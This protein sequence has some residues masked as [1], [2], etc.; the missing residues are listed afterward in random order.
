MN[1][2]YILIAEAPLLRPGLKIITY[3]SE[4]YTVKMLQKLMEIIREFNES[5][6]VE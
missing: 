5:E 2:K 4:K 3:G 1:N 6:V